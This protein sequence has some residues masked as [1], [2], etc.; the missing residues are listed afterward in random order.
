MNFFITDLEYFAYFLILP[1]GKMQE[2]NRA[3][4]PIIVSV[5]TCGLIQA[6]YHKYY[7]HGNILA[8]FCKIICCQSHR[9]FV[10]FQT[11]WLRNVQ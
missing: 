7:L 4:H 10:K 1:F 11:S 5:N 3:I 9:S 6:F 8:I 2:G